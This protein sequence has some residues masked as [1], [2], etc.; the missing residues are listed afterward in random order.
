MSYLVT[1][2]DFFEHPFFNSRYSK[3]CPKTTKNTG[4]TQQR[5]YF[6][7]QYLKIQKHSSM[8]LIFF[9]STCEISDTCGLFPLFVFEV[10]IYCMHNDVFRA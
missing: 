1:D 5:G 2:T 4:K 6:G 7:S 10:E 3:L 8:Y 9:E